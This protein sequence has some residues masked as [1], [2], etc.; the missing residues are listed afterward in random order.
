MK[1]LM[2]TQNPGKLQGAKEAFE[3]YFDDVEVEGIKVDSGV[4]DQPQNIQIYMGAHAR[5]LG[6]M[7]NARSQM[8][9]YDYYVAIESGITNFLG[10]WEIVNVAVI[11]DNEGKE[12][13]GTS[14]G[15]PVP[16]K[17]VQDVLDTDLGQVMDRIFNESELGKGKGGIG[18]LTKD[19]V[20]RIGLTKEAFV[21]ALTSIINGDK[22]RD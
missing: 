13:F 8:K 22:W 11:L 1:I 4:G 17:Y 14:A 6:A 5:A 2:G 20:T 18:M 21:M 3:E 19:V 9:N 7:Y 15:F 12:Y 16:E 10:K